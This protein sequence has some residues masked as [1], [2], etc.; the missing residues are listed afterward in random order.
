MI[1]M[2]QMLLAVEGNGHRKWAP[3]VSS[4]R[5]GCP[6]VLTLLGQRRWSGLPP[7]LLCREYCYS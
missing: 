2:S 3:L 6:N 7:R 4:A 1:G 5:V